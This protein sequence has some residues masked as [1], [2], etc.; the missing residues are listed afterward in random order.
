MFSR[1][2]D[3]SRH[4]LD[5]I[6]AAKELEQSLRS[7]VTMQLKFES[8]G[9]SGGTRFWPCQASRFHVRAH[10]NHRARRDF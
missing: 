4:T 6:V 1:D 7:D 8:I 9:Q 10:Y 3:M 2:L 5:M